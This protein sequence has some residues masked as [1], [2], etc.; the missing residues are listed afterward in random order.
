MRW[1]R[2]FVRLI[3]GNIAMI[4]HEFKRN[5][6]EEQQDVLIKTVIFD[7]DPYEIRTYNEVETKRRYRLGR[8]HSVIAVNDDDLPSPMSSYFEQSSIWL[9]LEAHLASKRYGYG[10]MTP[11]QRVQHILEYQPQRLKMYL[12]W[13][14]EY[15]LRQVVYEQNIDRWLQPIDVM[16]GEYEDED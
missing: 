13:K 4:Y 15:N 12:D 7:A 9:N 14:K 11:E 8:L 6:R 3:S 2:F 1:L 16:G 10:D 5:P